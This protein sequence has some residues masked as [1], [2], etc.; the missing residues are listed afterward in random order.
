VPEI[1]EVEQYRLSATKVVG[2]TIA[3]VRAPD[4][5]FLQPGDPSLVSKVLAGRR[6]LA[7]RRHG[8]L[9]ML[10]TTAAVVGIRFGM[11]GRLMVDGAGDPP[12]L[13]YTSGRDDPRWDRFALVFADGT[14][15][16]VQDP[17]RFGSVTLDP[18]ETLL[19]PDAFG[20]SLRDLRQGLRGTSAVKAALLDQSR[21]AG[22]GNLLV[23]EVLW[24]AG[25][26]P[27][28]PCADLDDDEIRAV[29]RAIRRRLVVLGRRGGSHLGDVPADQRVRG[30][31]CHRCDVELLRRTIGGRTTYS[32]PAHQR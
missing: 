7:A 13:G 8:K 27:A 1:L 6:V 9:L 26:D 29:H 22:L 31:R 11:T 4:A 23:D 18:D 12:V 30:V 14:R 5:G 32:C 20:L 25:V 2:A 15:L 28:R 19:G 17:R 16:R 3:E 10:D 24:H 21:V